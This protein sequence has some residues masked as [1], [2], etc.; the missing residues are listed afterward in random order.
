MGDGD[1]APCSSR[2]TR[3][4]ATLMTETQQSAPATACRPPKTF[5]TQLNT[6]NT[7]HRCSPLAPATR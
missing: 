5:T 7:E 6:L 2:M 3:D 1:G 4:S